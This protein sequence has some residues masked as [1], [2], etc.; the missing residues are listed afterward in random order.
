MTNNN[1]QIQDLLNNS[2][3]LLSNIYT[4]LGLIIDTIDSKKDKDINSFFSDELNLIKNI[5]LLT[6]DVSELAL[7]N[8][9]IKNLIK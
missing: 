7:I 5:E 1:K 3:S 9:N 6:N 2:S 8:T 4:T